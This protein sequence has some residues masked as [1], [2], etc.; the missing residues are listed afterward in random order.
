MPIVENGE[1]QRR[2]LLESAAAERVDQV[3]MRVEMRAKRRDIPALRRSDERA[4]RMHFTLRPGIACPDIAGE[5]L[6]RCVAPLLGDLVNRSS[7]AVGRGWV[8]ACGEGTP[9]RFDIS[10]TRGVEDAVAIVRGK[11]ESSTCVFSARQLVKP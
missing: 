7:V 10:V 6:D 3:R 2:G 5:Q 8:K 11:S 4:D 1:V 9:H